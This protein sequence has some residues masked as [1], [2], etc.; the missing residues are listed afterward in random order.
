MDRVYVAGAYSASD[1]LGVLENI[2]R[3]IKQCAKIL[4]EGKYAVYCPWLD[5]QYHFFEPDITVEQYQNNS[6]AWL[7]VSNVVIVLPDW[8]KSKGTK[9][10]IARAK[11]L[12]IEIV[13]ISE[14]L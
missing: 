5:H 1:V 7:E 14:G 8:E 9:R 12:G 3:G 13:F 4:K 2:R 11:Q 6:M 10:E